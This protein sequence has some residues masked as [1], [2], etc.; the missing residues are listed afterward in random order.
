MITTQTH[1][2]EGQATDESV[3]R[4]VRKLRRL[5]PAAY[6]DVMA[7]MPDG[8]RDALIYAEAR[9]DVLRDQSGGAACLAYPTT[10][11]TTTEAQS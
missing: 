7:A 11:E 4:L 1:M 2:T 8:A 6:A 10:D 9:A 3:L 5:H